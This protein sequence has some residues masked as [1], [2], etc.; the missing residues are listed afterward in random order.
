MV[1][2]VDL[3]IVSLVAL[4]AQAVGEVSMGVPAYVFLE[5]DP[6]AIFRPD[7]LAVNANRQEAVQRFDLI[8]SMPQ[9][10]VG[11]L[12]GTRHTLALF[13]EGSNQKSK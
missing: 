12:Q 9:S 13:F 7:L 2:F 3:R 6:I 4:R 10:L 1:L 5:P 11:L 8:Q